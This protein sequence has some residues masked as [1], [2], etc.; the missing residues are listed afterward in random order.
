MPNGVEFRKGKVKAY[1]FA[2]KLG[3]GEDLIEVHNA[4][5]KTRRGVLQL[6]RKTKRV[7]SKAI[8][9]LGTLESDAENWGIY[10]SFA[11]E[12]QESYQQAFLNS[13]QRAMEKYQRQVTSDNWAQSA[14]GRRGLYLQKRMHYAEI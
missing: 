4:G 1:A 7:I 3:E 14:L 9:H 6:D 2:D 11:G 5:F 8:K 12:D 10:I 13:K